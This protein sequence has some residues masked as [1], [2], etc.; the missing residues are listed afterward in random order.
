MTVDVVSAEQGGAG[1]HLEKMGAVARVASGLSH[2]VADLLDEAASAIHLALISEQPST[3]LAEAAATLQRAG[4]IARQLEAL[5]RSG[6]A[7]VAP[8][9]L[10]DV[11]EEVLPLLRRLAGSAIDVQLL[12]ID[13]AAWVE[14]GSGQLEQVLFHLTVNARD[15]MPGGGII[16][17]RVR[18]RTLEAPHAH[19]YGILAPGSW[20]ILD[21]SDTGVGMG[22]EVLSR[23]FEPFFTTKSPGLGSGLGLATVYGVAR[24][25]GGQVTVSSAPQEGATVGLWLPATE[26]AT[27]TEA[28][29][30]AT[31][32]AVLVVDDDDWVRSVT[33]RALKRAGYGVLEAGSADEALDLL[34]DVAGGCI[35]AV[36][37]DIAMPGMTGGELASRIRAAHPTVRMVFM[38]GRGAAAAAAVA[39]PAD[40]VLL[41][42]F[43][44]AE[45][46]AAIQ[47]A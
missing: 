35:R 11:L 42:P 34:R 38:T 33:V 31:D 46:L 9:R 37:T 21:V 26:P 5:G 6:P 29:R 15:A 44:R 41:K 1:A 3:Q 19:R 20:C 39:G 27:P 47:A 18:Q 8:C 13:R 12:E 14:A 36:L 17:I 24:Q 10:A 22:E 16:G 45:L 32:D 30:P 23:L 28:E 2:D 25:L 40:G 7:H 4:L 43:S